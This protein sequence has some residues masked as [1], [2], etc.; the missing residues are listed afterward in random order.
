MKML[1][2]RLTEKLKNDKKAA[3]ILAV[4]L[5]GMLLLLLSCYGGTDKKS[6]DA[7]D[8]PVFSS[9]E[10]ETEKRLETLLGEVKNVGRV[11]VAVTYDCM[12][13]YEYAR[14]EK[15]QGEEKN[16]NE[17]V[18]VDD[19]NADAG[20]KL[21][22]T[23]PKVRGVAVC[24]DGASSDTV[25]EEVTRLVCAVLGIGANKVYVSQMKE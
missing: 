7:K 24:C 4:G 5:L 3:V 16:E 11:K 1:K 6:T 10:R 23:A 25:K 9:L 22:V 17:Y 13:E 19:G 18:I 8:A 12:E 15:K 14:D 21:R 20:L 2:N